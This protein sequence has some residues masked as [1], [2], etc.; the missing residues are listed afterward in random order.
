MAAAAKAE[1]VSLQVV[2]SGQEIELNVARE[3]CP[4]TLVYN[5][6]WSS[7]RYYNSC[8]WPTTSKI[9]WLEKLAR[10]LQARRK[11]GEKIESFGVGRISVSFPDAA[12]A[13]VV[14]AHADKDWDKAKGR[15]T[16]TGKSTFIHVNHLFAALVMRSDFPKSFEKTLSI[17]GYRVAAASVE[18]VLIGTPNE[19][20]FAAEL[21]AADIT[22]GKLPF[23]ALVWL[24]L[25]PVE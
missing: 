23:D 16:Q 2:D 19:T 13:I 20:P 4:A 22:N 9:E 25:T 21:K 24:T 17:L 11:E 5:R 6:R 1:S 10:A 8:D 15:L 18:K 7:L 12:Q 3:G 14:A